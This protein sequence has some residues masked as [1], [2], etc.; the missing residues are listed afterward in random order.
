MQSVEEADQRQR[1][2]RRKEGV[3]GRVAIEH[4]T[5]RRA[6]VRIIEQFQPSGLLLGY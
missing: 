1:A 2:G 5:L 4:P 6:L 3:T